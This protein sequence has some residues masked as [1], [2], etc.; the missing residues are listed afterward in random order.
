MS[1]TVSYVF[2]LVRGA[3]R[4]V[5][6]DIPDGMPGGSDLRA[7]EVG[8]QLWAIVETVREADYGEA[9]LV[10]GLQNLDWVGERA[11]A[12]ERVIERFLS[13][14][15]V[16]PMQLFTMFTS[17]ERVVEHVRADGRRIARILKRIDRKVEWGLRLTWD[18]KAARENVE[19][20]HADPKGPRR[21]A[22]APKSGA[23][24]PAPKSG[25]DL[26]GPRAREGAA[27]LARKRD[28]LDVN[29]A[30]LAEARVE[31]GRLY[32]AISRE[33]TEALRRTSLERAAPG[34][35]LLLD[36]AFLV[37]AAKAAAFRASLRKHSRALRGSGVAVSLTGPWP[38]Y[39]FIEPPSR[40]SASGSQAPPSRSGASARQTRP[41]RADTSARQ[42]R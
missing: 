10:R 16:L 18:E 11:V 14:P 26:S 2:C 33:A 6:R 7:I 22:A 29:R 13:A 12:H 37:P 39:N 24:R 4:P 42:A 3:R 38:P 19:R 32:K 35:R 1:V 15:A 28:I 34:S 27:Y 20:K 9:A 25:A 17:D 40:T 8:D 36:A 5:V 23:A 30:Q 21:R 41:S 31:A